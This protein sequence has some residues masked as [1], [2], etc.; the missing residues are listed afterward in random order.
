[1]KLTLARIAE[2]LQGK[3]EFDPMAI[4]TGYSIDSRTIGPGELFFAVSGERLDGHDFV[5]AALAKGAVAAVVRRDQLSR[6]TANAQLIAVDDAL[7]ALQ[8][9]AAALRRLW[10]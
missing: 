4:A 8:Q 9:L 3:G 1:M 7:V 10:G 6:F 5:D 2:F